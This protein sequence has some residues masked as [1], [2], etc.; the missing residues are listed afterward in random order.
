MK[1][2]DIM[3]WDSKGNRLESTQQNIYNIISKIKYFII[4]IPIIVLTQ[5]LDH[6]SRQKV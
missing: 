2:I 6:F 1:T 4:I 3:F 5:F